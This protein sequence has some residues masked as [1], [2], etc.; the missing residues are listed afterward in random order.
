MKKINETLP[1]ETTQNNSKN[2]KHYFLKL[3]GTERTLLENLQNFCFAL[4]FSNSH[5]QKLSEIP[6]LIYLPENTTIS[7]SADFDVYIKEFQ[8]HPFFF[9]GT[10]NLLKKSTNTE[11]LNP[12]LPAFIFNMNQTEIILYIADINKICQ[13]QQ[14]FLE[15]LCPWGSAF[16]NCILL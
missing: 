11:S 8:K 5:K 12:S 10:N 1:L 7:D 13:K 3:L 9:T 15:N 6:V 14:D 2:V 4:S 16:I